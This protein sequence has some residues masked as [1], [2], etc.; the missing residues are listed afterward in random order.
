MLSRMPAPQIHAQEIHI[1]TRP[2]QSKPLAFGGHYLL[3]GT[4]EALNDHMNLL[5]AKDIE[6]ECANLKSSKE[7][8]SKEEDTLTCLFITGQE[9]IQHFR[10]TAPPQTLRPNPQEVS[11]Q[12]KDRIQTA[13]NTKAIE[14]FLIVIDGIKKEFCQAMQIRSNPT[15]SEFIQHITQAHLSNVM[16]ATSINEQLKQ[17]QFNPLTQTTGMTL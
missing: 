14:D 11:A 12:F 8:S 5:L 2:L 17:G 9:D 4:S 6:M 15:W 16:S 7:E 1:Q 10:A 13:L 3:S